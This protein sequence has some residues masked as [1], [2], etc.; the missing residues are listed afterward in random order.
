MSKTIQ[1][2]RVFQDG[3]DVLGEPVSV[4][5]GKL[6]KVSEAVAAEET[7]MPLSFA[8][9][10][11]EL[12]H[13]YILADFD[14]LIETNDSAAPDETIT[15]KEGIPLEWDAESG[16]FDNPLGAVDVTVLYVTTAAGE[17]GTLEI[18]ALE[19]PTP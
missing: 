19:D 5:A 4:E 3:S 9:D 10:V 15:I 14:C 2:N 1:F 8:S 6:T 13:L 18:R 7:D 17:S 12:K 11:S 16:Y